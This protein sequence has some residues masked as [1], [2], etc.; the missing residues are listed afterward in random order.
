MNE[1]KTIIKNVHKKIINLDV[2]TEK[3]QE[4]LE[5]QKVDNLRVKKELLRKGLIQ[6]DTL[7]ETKRK[8]ITAI[9]LVQSIK[10]NSTQIDNL[11]NDLNLL[12]EQEKKQSIKKKE[13]E[14]IKSE[15]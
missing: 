2:L 13:Y 14:S 12:T 8:L 3:I 6:I 1:K 15:I 7:T 10:N 5:I 11:T 4:F 9:D